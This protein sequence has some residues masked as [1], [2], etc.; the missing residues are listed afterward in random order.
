M[1][2]SRHPATRHQV[3]SAWCLHTAELSS[4]EEK[5][6]G[7]L[8]GEWTKLKIILLSELTCFQKDKFMD[9]S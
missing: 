7:P 4:A 1:D 3:E 9:I 5:G 2:Q 8:V 6:L